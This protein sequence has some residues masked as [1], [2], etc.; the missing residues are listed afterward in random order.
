MNF[1]RSALGMQC[2]LASLFFSAAIGLAPL[3]S[4]AQPRADE[5]PFEVSAVV[6]TNRP[7]NQCVPT[8]ALGAGVDGHIRIS[9]PASPVK[10]V[11]RIRNGW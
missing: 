1:A 6:L 9:I 11:M 4:Q 8:Q 3:A 5:K 10:L 7:V 2:V